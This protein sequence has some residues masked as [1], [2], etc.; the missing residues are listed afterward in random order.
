MNAASRT[1]GR[2]TFLDCV[3][4][5]AALS[6]LFE[7][8]GD[9]LS[10][11][12]RAFTHDW[13]SFGKFGVAA[14]FL[15]SG[16]VIPFSLERG[17]SLKRFW[18]SRFFRL[19]PLYWLSIA[20][21]LGVYLM[22]GSYVLSPAY[23]SHFTRNTIV[24]LSMFQEFVGVPDAQGLYYT[25]SM[26]MAFY[27]F[28]SFLYRI[29]L[30]RMSLRIAWIGS[31]LLATSGLLMPLL[32]HKRVPLAGLFYFLCLF[33]GTSIYRHFTRE[34]STKAV[35]ILLGCVAVTTMAEIY[36]NYVLIKKDDVTEHY[37]L[38][39]VLLPWAGA[40]SLFLAAYALKKYRFP[41]L[42]VWLGAVSYSVYVLNS[43]LASL[44]PMWPHRIYS[45][46][47]TLALTLTVATITYRLVEQ[48]FISLGKRVQARLEML[49]PEAREVQREDV[50][51][52]VAHF[53]AP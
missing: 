5:I 40:Y 28:F 33:V 4:G 10:P 31:G 30:N 15:T 46:V 47:A 32:F 23:V 50:A 34:A 44:V 42:F 2:L 16:F 43:P 51:A 13:F 6:V 38:W 20:V 19:Y 48:P 17:G 29:K 26:E 8:V 22:G 25:L 36:C 37:T 24:N 53:A 12:F 7:H 9:R 18:V 49:K 39:A 21:A 27:I 41:K 1:Q 11:H 35:T 52:E 45:F 14:F 3:R